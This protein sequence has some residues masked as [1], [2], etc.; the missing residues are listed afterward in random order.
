MSDFENGQAVEITVSGEQGVIVSGPYYEVVYALNN[1]GTAV[2]Q[3]WPA[4]CLEV[5]SEDDDIPESDDEHQ[6]DNDNSAVVLV[7]PARGAA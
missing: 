5:V 3:I 7:F 2:R 1:E 6:A 4:Q